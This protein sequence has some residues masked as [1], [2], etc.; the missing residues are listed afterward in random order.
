VFILDCCFDWAV[1]NFFVDDESQSATVV[2]GPVCSDE[3]VA[4]NFW[5]TGFWVPF[6]LLDSRDFDV[7][8]LHKVDDV[9]DFAAD[10]VGIELENF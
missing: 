2:V 4:I 9:V 3:R 7:I 1:L 10:A 8:M 6:R 5:S